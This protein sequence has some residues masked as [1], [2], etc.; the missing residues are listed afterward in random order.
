MTCSEMKLLLYVLTLININLSVSNLQIE[1]LEE[2]KE[3]RNSDRL[4]FL[5]N[6]HTYNKNNNTIIN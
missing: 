1:K 6:S 3:I 4:D 2:K 5:R